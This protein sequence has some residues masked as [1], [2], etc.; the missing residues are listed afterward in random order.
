MRYPERLA[1]V[2]G[3]SDWAVV[4]ACAKLPAKQRAA[5]LLGHS[6]DLPVAEVVHLMDPRVG[7]TKRY[8]HLARR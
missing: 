5:L 6:R 2:L 3:E 7:T 4:E 1:E 8:L